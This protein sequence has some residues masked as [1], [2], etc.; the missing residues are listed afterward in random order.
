MPSVSTG[1]I[2]GHNATPSHQKATLEGLPEG[3]ASDPPFSI[4]SIRMQAKSQFHAK[5]HYP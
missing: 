1:T 5:A 3:Q 4:Q 2:T